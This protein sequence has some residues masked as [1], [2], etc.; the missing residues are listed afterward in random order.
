MIIVSFVA[1]TLTAPF[2]DIKNAPSSF[3][4]TLEDTLSEMT[5]ELGIADEVV[6]IVVVGTYAYG[7]ARLDDDQRVSDLDVVIYTRALSKDPSAYLEGFEAFRRAAVRYRCVLQERLGTDLDFDIKVDTRD[8]ATHI[9]DSDWVGYSLRER[10]LF[11]RDDGKPRSVKG[12]FYKDVYYLF[13]RAQYQAYVRELPAHHYR[14]KTEIEDDQVVFYD[15]AA[16][17]IGE[18]IELL[19]SFHKN[20]H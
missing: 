12:H 5:D 13:D 16:W 3:L 17:A 15:G 2:N 14:I 19:R 18:R 8:L 11:N 20:A 4:N 9:A 1:L 10:R 6:D 7:I